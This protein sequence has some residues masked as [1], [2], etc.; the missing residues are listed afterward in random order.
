MKLNPRNDLNR[1]VDGPARKAGVAVIPAVG[2]YGGF[3]DL[4]ATVVSERWDGVDDMDVMIGLDSW[5][6]TRG[7]RLTGE[8]NTARRKV[9]EEGLLLPVQ[10]PPVERKWEFA[11]PVGQQAMLE[12]P[13]SEVILISRH[14][15]VRTLHT[16]LSA[17]ALRNIR[18]ATTPGPDVDE[19]GR[20][21][22][23]FVVEVVATSAGSTRRI[24]AKG[25]DI[26][27]F[28]AALVCEVVARI[29]RPGFDRAGAY[30]PG[31]VLDA[32][33]VLT[34]LQPNH[35]TFATFNALSAS[36]ES[37]K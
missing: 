26:Y 36:G 31:E 33:D 24:V 34:A 23:R 19:T 20:S 12:V 11:E 32:R 8:R 22:Q 16:Y 30:A 18:D 35:M 17:N 28:S 29:L 9:V 13:F 4:L 37:R 21:S 6:P 1:K 3:A 10:L 7:T 25:R 14:L 5:H 27:A 2:F 15:K